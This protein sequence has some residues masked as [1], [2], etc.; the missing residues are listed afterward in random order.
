MFEI[1]QKVK[2]KPE[3]WKR[4]LI[5]NKMDMNK[6]APGPQIITYLPSNNLFSDKIMLSFP[7]WWWNED[8]LIPVET[9]YEEVNYI[10]INEQQLKIGDKVSCTCEYEVSKFYPVWHSDTGKYNI[11]TWNDKDYTTWTWQLDH[12]IPR[13]NLPYSSMTDENFKKCW[14]LENLRPYSAKLNL[15]DGVMIIRHRKI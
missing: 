5:E 7:L 15:L 14:A 2:I 12:I 1:G 9:K 3:A 10:I 11:L 13:S 4:F 8:D 6:P